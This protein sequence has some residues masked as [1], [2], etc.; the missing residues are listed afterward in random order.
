MEHLNKLLES[1][2]ADVR[3]KG[4]EHLGQRMTE[5]KAHGGYMSAGARY[6]GNREVWTRCPDCEEAELAAQL[7]AQSLAEAKKKQAQINEMLLGTSIPKRFVGRNFDNYLTSTPE[8]ERALTIAREY[9]ENFAS[10]LRAG[11]GL[12]LSGLPGTGKSHLAGAVLQHIL[13]GHVGLYVTCMS[14]IRAVRNT[15]SKQSEKSETEVIQMFASVPLLVVD[16]VGVQYGTDGEQTIIF[17]VLDLRYREMMPTILLTN[18]DKN[19]FKQFI[20]ERS[21]DRLVE[22]SRWVSFDWGSYRATARKA[23]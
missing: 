4:G 16:E 17:D 12:V 13:P 15:W 3:S 5:C 21:F 6:F 7:A 14:M 19:G 1:A 20:G 22:T 2:I 11:T 9:A 18:Q 8:Q 10:H 23:A